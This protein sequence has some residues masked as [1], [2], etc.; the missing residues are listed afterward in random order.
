MILTEATLQS[1]SIFSRFQDLQT[2]DLLRYKLYGSEVFKSD[3]FY[4]ESYE[5]FHGA[6]T[7]KQMR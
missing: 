7:A 4:E 5:Q 3:T 1:K 2:W 6:I